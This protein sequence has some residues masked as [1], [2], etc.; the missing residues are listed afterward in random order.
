[1]KFFL[2]LA[3]VVVI[4]SKGQDCG[5]QSFSTMILDLDDFVLEQDE[6]PCAEM[7]IC[8]YYCPDCTKAVNV[9]LDTKEPKYPELEKTY[10]AVCG[11]R[12][13]RKVAD[14]IRDIVKDLTKDLEKVKEDRKDKAS[15]NRRIEKSEEMGEKLINFGHRIQRLCDNGEITYKTPKSHLQAE[16]RRYVEETFKGSDN[17]LK[18]GQRYKNLA[19][20]V[21]ERIVGIIDRSKCPCSSIFSNPLPDKYKEAFVQIKNQC[22]KIC[23]SKQ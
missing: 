14:I 11:K 6:D 21:L 13:H 17:D 15:F 2:L 8:L 16:W 7:K 9:R 12:K 18:N 23:E 1:M 5:K 4:L 10:D 22:L 19:N 20:L 3:L